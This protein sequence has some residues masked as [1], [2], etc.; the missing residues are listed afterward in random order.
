MFNRRI[1]VTK[2][3]VSNIISNDSKLMSYIEKMCL[4]N[5][6]FRSSVQYIYIYIIF[7]L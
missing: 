3:T 4:V 5:W 6:R 1:F 7:A 2:I